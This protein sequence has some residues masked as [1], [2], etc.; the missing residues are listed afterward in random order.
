MSV[1]FT[2]TL[3]NVRQLDFSS[4]ATTGTISAGSDQLTV[5]SAVG[6]SI[7][8]SIIIAVG[9]EAGAGARGTRGVGGTWPALSYANTATMNADSSKAAGTWAWVEASGN[10]YRYT[11]GVWTQVSAVDYYVAKVVPR[12][13]I[14]TITGKT[15]NVLTLADEASVDATGADVYFD[16]LPIFDAA[17]ALGGTSVTLNMAAGTF[18]TSDRFILLAKHNWRL[19]GAGKESTTVFSPDGVFGVNGIWAQV[20]NYVVFQDFHYKG[21]ARQNGFGLNI[22][23]TSDA[24]G[25]TYPYGVYLREG[26]GGIGRRLKI[27]DV[28]MDGL[29][30]EDQDDCWFSDCTV[31]QNEP[32]RRYIQWLI[33]FSGCVG[34]GAVDCE[35]DS[36]WLTAGFEAFNCNGTHFI[37]VIGRNA[38]FSLN[39]SGNFLI[40]DAELTFEANIQ[41]D[42]N[43][44]SASVP[45]V[46]VN[47]NFGVSYAEF[48]GTIT[49]I[50]MLQEGYI[51]ADNDSLKGIIINADNPNVTV[52]GGIHTAPDYAEPSLLNGSQGYDARNAQNPVLRNFTVI[53]T[54]KEGIGSIHI[55]PTGTLTNCTAQVIIGP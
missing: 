19:Q 3:N 45:I 39:A 15:G 34:G 40:E 12:A 24:H 55:S 10:V 1:D 9:G 46:N 20:S 13:L 38:A 2:F 4:A 53:G 25:Q 44:L 31:V 26:V 48:G 16:N 22:T 36:E 37:R 51:N 41:F 27:T 47:A 52:D 7:G 32:L 49:N 18:A 30:A 8:N 28:F 5:A 11:A 29:G 33:Q 23:E 54:P 6:F 14:T 35:V 43:S 42:A 50:T 21:N 17:V